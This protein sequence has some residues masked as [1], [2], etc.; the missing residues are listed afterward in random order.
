MEWERGEAGE[1]GES[2]G[3]VCLCKAC[4]ARL[5]LTM[6]CHAMHASDRCRSGGGGGCQG[7]TTSTSTPCGQSGDA[8]N[9]VMIPR[10]ILCILL[11]RGIMEPA[12]A[13]RAMTDRPMMF[14]VRGMMVMHPTVRVMTRNCPRVGYGRDDDPARCG[15]PL[16]SPFLLVRL[17]SLFSQPYLVCG[18]LS[19]RVEYVMYQL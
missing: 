18:A 6:P 19:L 13:T 1:A 9:H 17:Q 3:R 7:T 5:F 14:V 11:R 16:Q 10:E 12:W 4:H 8:R 15:L 2:I